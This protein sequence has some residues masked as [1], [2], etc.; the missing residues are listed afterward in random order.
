ML[1]LALKFALVGCVTLTT[2]APIAL[3]AD[4]T[5][6][7]RSLV[8]SRSDRLP[9]LAA[10]MSIALPGSG[11]FYA[12]DEWWRPA[13]ILGGLASAVLL[14][15]L[16]DQSRRSLD[17]NGN[18]SPTNARLDSL[19]LGFQIGIPSLWLWNVAD[20][21]QATIRHNK[22]TS[23]ETEELPRSRRLLRPDELIDRDDV[24]P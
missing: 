23:E 9:A 11:Q 14:Y 24:Q 6:E 15:A 1:S 3:A 10:A 5:D 4:S 21:Y 20:A 8:E 18:I 19:A 12:G 22:L 7:T 13:L 2:W 16:I 17:A